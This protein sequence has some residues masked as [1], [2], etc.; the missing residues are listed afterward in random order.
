M[1]SG[2][3]GE[4]FRLP[5]EPFL[6]RYPVEGTRVR[7]AFLDPGCNR[8]TCASTW[9]PEIRDSQTRPSTSGLWMWRKLGVDSPTA[10]IASRDFTPN[11]LFCNIGF[12]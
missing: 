5:A 11:S 6:Q 12:G 1:N 8:F 4:W 3:I 9:L 10:F 2:K 7:E